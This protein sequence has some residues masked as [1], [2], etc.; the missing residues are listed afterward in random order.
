MKNIFKLIIFILMVSSCQTK[1][2]KNKEQSK[3][4]FNIVQVKTSE[5][6]SSQESP[7]ID[8]LGV[9]L[10]E[11]EAKPSFKT[12]GVI[13]RAFFKEGDY[14]KKGQL[15]A[16][17]VMSEIDAQVQQAEQGLS[18]AERDLAR[19]KNLH[20]DSVATLEQLQNVNTGYELAK[21]SVEIARF[22]RNFS[23]VR[24][25]I[26]G[27][28]IKQIMHSGEI[29]GPG[30]PVYAILGV[31]DADW[32]INLGLIDRDWARVKIGDKANIAM[33]AYPGKNFDGVVSNKTSVGGNASGTFDIEI[34]F[35]NNP[36]NLAAGILTKIKIQ[37]KVSE[38][39]KLIPIEALIKTNGSDA[40]AFTIVDGKAK[41]ISLKISKLLGDKVAISSGLEGVSEII[42]TGAMYLEDG[43]LVKK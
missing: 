17:L 6:S 29:V 42:T 32:K 40:F 34:K 27:K 28:I 30:T 8:G 19:V 33:E 9:V 5:I 38:S 20:A 26:S 13:Q 35:K 22:N 11:T 15:L 10:S 4:D 37:S 7:T 24:A 2:T 3:T 16:T 36:P 25:P 39:M 41:R 31:G 18:K 1:A 14:V 12:G 23:E 43:D 21:R